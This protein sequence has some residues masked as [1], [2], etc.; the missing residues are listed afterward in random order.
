[1]PPVPLQLLTVVKGFPEK[2]MHLPSPLGWWMPTQPVPS[3]IPGAARRVA[4]E[5]QPA[6]AL[7]LRFPAPP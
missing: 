5:R 6:G 1:M 7:R 2:L 4:T 3:A